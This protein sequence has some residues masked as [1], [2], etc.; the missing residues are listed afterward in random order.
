MIGRTFGKWSVVAKGRKRRTWECECSCGRRRQVHESNLR[1]GASRSCGKHDRPPGKIKHGHTAGGV[2]S[3][4]YRTWTQ[5][6]VRCA[7]ARAPN[8][9]AYGGSGVRVCAA[10]RKSFEAFLRDMGPRPVG[11]SIDRIDNRKGYA[12]GNCRWA[13]PAEQANNRSSTHWLTFGGET[14]TL[15][16]WAR[17]IGIS[18]TGLLA[19]VRLGQTPPHIL[20]PSRRPNP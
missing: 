6:L 13:T 10:W 16:A 20:R 8:F 1:S 15:T 5:M 14:K 7:N 18:D 3:P 9:K 12:P 2:V 19:R 17:Q 4:E 11:T